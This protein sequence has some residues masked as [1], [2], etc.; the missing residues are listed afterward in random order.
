MPLLDHFHP[1]LSTQRPW[2]GIHSAWAAT[3]ARQLND[4]LLPPDYFAMPHVTVGVRV[5]ADV[6]AY[7]SPSAPDGNGSVALQT[8]APP[9]PA[10]TAVVDFVQL[11]S[12]EVQVY[13]EM[14][15]AKLRA[16]IEIVS[17][18]NKDRDSHRHAF[19]VK[20]GA[21]LQQGI[22]LL[23]VDVVTE[24][25][26]NLHAHLIEVLQQ[27]SALGWQSPSDLSAVAYRA[28]P[29]SNGD[30]IEVW[31]ETLTV[32]AELPTMPLWLEPETCVPVRLEE[33]YV[34]TCES[35]RI[36]LS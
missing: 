29:W 35:L 21:Y 24:R 32:G 14:G 23:V 31:T 11:P 18:A 26:A 6:V 16:V 25:K 5:E 13:Q 33:S 10:L 4:A 30:R 28:V 9:K 2:E 8:W 34:A 20:C 22:G 19:A 7:R 3:I 1:P 15:G 27:A 12:F 36:P 17:P